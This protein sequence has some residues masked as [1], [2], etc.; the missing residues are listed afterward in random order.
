MLFGER[1]DRGAGGR[2]G[3]VEGGGRWSDAAGGVLHVGG[4]VVVDAVVAGDRG[5]RGE[6]AAAVGDEAGGIVGAEAADLAAVVGVLLGADGVVGE[7]DAGSDGELRRDVVF[8]LGEGLVGVLDEGLVEVGKRSVDQWLSGIG[9][10]TG[11]GWCWT[12]RT[13]CRREG[14]R[15]SRP[16]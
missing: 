5:K 9:R 14:C 16:G 15:I 8:V 12:R 6:V 3:E 11:G 2:L 4:P 1:G 13:T 7:L 10:G